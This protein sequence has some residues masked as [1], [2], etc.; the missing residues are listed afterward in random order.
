MTDPDGPK[1]Y[2]YGSKSGYTALIWAYLHYSR[3]RRN[4]VSIWLRGP[5]NVDQKVFSKFFAYYFLMVT[6]YLHQSSK[7][8][9]PK[10]VTKHQGLSYFSFA[11]HRRVQIGIWIRTNNDPDPEG[12]QTY[13]S[14][15]GYTALI[16]TYLHY[17]RW[18]RN[19]VSI[20]LMVPRNGWPRPSRTSATFST[21]SRRSSEKSSFQLRYSYRE[22]KVT[23]FVGS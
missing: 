12:S 6:V 5:R 20:W 15:S 3:W 11:W 16:W 18:R 7:V 17:S 2:G 19:T 9:S 13:G 14:G 22:L 10:E 1:T 21:S 8:K 4:T 23:N